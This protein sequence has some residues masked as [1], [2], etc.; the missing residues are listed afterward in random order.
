MAK[1][2]LQIVEPILRGL[3]LDSSSALIG[4]AKQRIIDMLNETIHELNAIRGL[5]VLKKTGTITLVA[6]TDTY[7]LASDAVSSGLLSERLYIY[8][9]DK[10]IEKVGDDDFNKLLVV[11]DSGTPDYW[12]PFGTTAAGVHQIQVYPNPAVADA[13]RV[14]Q[15]DYYQQFSDLSADADVSINDISLI[16]K[17]IKKLYAEYDQEFS[18]SDREERRQSVLIRKIKAHNMGGRGM[19]PQFRRQNK[20]REVR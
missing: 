16:Q 17:G 12:R 19:Q 11:G 3:G 2:V 15:Y 8:A 6:S 7:D 4:D 5:N 1:N 9:S 14:M 20:F 18:I 10:E 13:G